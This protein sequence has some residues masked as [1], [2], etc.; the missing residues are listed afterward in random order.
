V[1]AA[2]GVVS[3]PALEIDPELE[4]QLTAGF[5]A[6]VTAAE[7]VTVAPGVTLVGE[8]VTETATGSEAGH[9]VIVITDPVRLAI[10]PEGNPLIVSV[11]L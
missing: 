10:H 4:L 9:P 6:L 11:A 2:A 8:Q 7:Q 5:A 1:P 3:T